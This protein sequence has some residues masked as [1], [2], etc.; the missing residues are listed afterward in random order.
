MGGRTLEPMSVSILIGLLFAFVLYKLFS[1]SAQK[2]RRFLFTSDQRVS[3]SF[4]RDNSGLMMFSLQLFTLADRKV[5]SGI[6][7]LN[8][9]LLKQSQIRTT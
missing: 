2:T 6:P 9:L 3:L 7:A 8:L 1:M 4:W 5:R